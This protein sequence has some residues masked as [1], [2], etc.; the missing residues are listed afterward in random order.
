M[1][2]PTSQ[3]TR[4]AC[5]EVGCQNSDNAEDHTHLIAEN[6]AVE[7]EL[8]SV[9][10]SDAVSV[11][12]WFEA[13][14]WT[15]KTSTVILLTHIVAACLKA[16]D[17]SS[18][19]VKNG[20]IHTAT[21]TYQNLREMLF[22]FMRFTMLSLISI[23]LIALATLASIGMAFLPRNRKKHLLDA[24]AWTADPAS[25]D[26]IKA[27]V[28][29]QIRGT[30]ADRLV[31]VGHSQGG[32]ILSDI[33]KDWK[34]G[35]VPT[36]IT[37]GSGQVVLKIAHQIDSG[38]KT[39]GAFVYSAL[40]ISY[41]IVALFFILPLLSQLMRFIGF[42]VMSG[43]VF[44]FDLWV[45]ANDLTRGLRMMV[46]HLQAQAS[47]IP[48]FLGPALGYPLALMVVVVTIFGILFV[49]ANLVFKKQ[50]NDIIGALKEGQ[51]SV[52]G[53]DITARQDY[54][55]S[56]MSVMG[57]PGRVRRIPMR[58]IFP[59]DHTSYFIHNQLALRPIV[60]SVEDSPE[61]GTS[62][63]TLES[64]RNDEVREYSTRLHG[65]G[66]TIAL[67][68]GV[69]SSSVGLFSS[70]ENL[71]AVVLI[72]LAMLAATVLLF[73]FATWLVL[74]RSSR[75]PLWHLS[76]A[77]K[78]RV[79]SRDAWTGG[80][81]LMVGIFTLGVQDPKAPYMALIAVAFIASAIM[82][83]SGRAMAA[84]IGT[85]AFIV[86]G[87]SWCSTASALGLFVATIMFVAGGVVMAS[88]I[89]RERK[90]AM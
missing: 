24:M 53:A 10:W 58:G 34:S 8:R 45:T 86:F 89:R 72:L 21:G 81:M 63:A 11:P 51:L 55:S 5:S 56:P 69:L 22:W 38:K 1:R 75:L 42:L 71:L 32:A 16:V 17:S 57:N 82:S 41:G 43:M 47:V 13:V 26:N 40:A 25:R 37:L 4:K 61:S 59:F 78:A 46:Q 7:A 31:L 77:W 3:W 65:A 14:K 70:T 19:Q 2:S 39:I 85:F 68:A 73:V 79:A 48:T 60:E 9:Y 67:V 84:P 80:V 90:Q 33:V 35:P 50:V 49:V 23:P 87:I 27:S 64:R 76:D 74:R 62:S 30:Q 52:D 88:S 83:F 29:R 18:Q 36:L 66:W 54:V 12:R 44:S 28:I 15:A 20:S 6:A